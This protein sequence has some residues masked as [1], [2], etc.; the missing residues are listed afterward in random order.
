MYH[1]NCRHAKGEEWKKEQ[2]REHPDREV[3]PHDPNPKNC[4]TT[5]FKNTILINL[6]TALKGNGFLEV[7]RFICEGNSR[8]GPVVAEFNVQEKNGRKLH[9]T[10]DANCNSN[11]QVPL[12]FEYEYGR[13]VSIPVSK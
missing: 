11:L 2:E 1:Y 10:F 12:D 8:D 13:V 7:K 3:H 5:H 6:T 9:V 4:N